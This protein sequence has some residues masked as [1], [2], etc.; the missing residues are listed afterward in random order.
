MPPW[1]KILRA[2]KG[3]RVPRETAPGLIADAA[4]R[5][6]S[7]NEV[8]ELRD[9]ISNTL[10]IRGTEDAAQI[11]PPGKLRDRVRDIGSN[12]N[13]QQIAGGGIG[14]LG[15][16]VL[17][18][19]V[20]ALISGLARGRAAAPRGLLAGIPAA[21]LGYGAGQ[22]SVSRLQLL[23][24]L[25]DDLGPGAGI[26]RAKVE[27][28]FGEI[29]RQLKEAKQE[30]TLDFSQL[31]VAVSDLKDGRGYGLNPAER[32]LIRRNILDKTASRG[33]TKVGVRSSESQAAPFRTKSAAMVL[34][35]SEAAFTALGLQPR[36]N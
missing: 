4:K 18:A 3:L 21:A 5:Q 31:K 9:D 17:G 8:E 14:A 22:H 30:D 13:R 27:E 25:K 32:H 35:G 36:S 15:G 24:A 12:T 19:G 26:K 28:G 1:N 20:G 7:D 10:A 33:N 23:S 6:Y 29:L 11:V 16:G 34:A 2:G